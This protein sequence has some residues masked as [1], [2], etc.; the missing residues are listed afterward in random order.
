MLLRPSLAT[1]LALSEGRLAVCA[2][3]ASWLTSRSITSSVALLSVSS[4]SSGCTPSAGSVDS[5]A[6][7]A[8][9]VTGLTGVPSVRTSW[10]VSFTSGRCCRHRCR[11]LR[12]LRCIVPT[13]SFFC[14]ANGVFFL[15]GCGRYVCREAQVTLDEFEESDERIRARTKEAKPP[16]PKHQNKQAHPN[17]PPK[18]TENGAGSC[19]LE[20]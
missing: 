8:A 18:E 3:E 15:H 6:L 2:G 19:P 11:F 17:S 13:C 5:A 20:M 16:R 12:R 14:A 10:L 4:A 9:Q 7:A 1:A